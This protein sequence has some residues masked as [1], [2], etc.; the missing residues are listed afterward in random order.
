MRVGAL[1]KLLRTARPVIERLLDLQ[2]LP[3]V[4]DPALVT[5]LMDLFETHGVSLFAAVA[6]C[7]GRDQDWLER[8]DI[9]EFVQLCQVVFEV[10]R[11]FFAERLAPLL[12]G[13]FENTAAMT[14]AGPTPSSSS[15]SAATT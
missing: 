2:D 13:L 12:A 10:N 4:G 14:G 6:I 15:S 5:L 11:D 8:G 9:A 3:E 1:P 7:T